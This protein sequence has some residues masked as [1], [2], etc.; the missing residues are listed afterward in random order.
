LTAFVYRYL[1]H[2]GTLRALSMAKQMFAGDLTAQD[3][4]RSLDQNMVRALIR[5]CARIA[6]SRETPLLALEKTL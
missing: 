3:F 1:G 5:A 4:L 2:D 6:L